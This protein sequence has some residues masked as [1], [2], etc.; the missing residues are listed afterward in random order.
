MIK[1][2][3]KMKYAVDIYSKTSPID[4]DPW[5]KIDHFSTLNQATIFCKIVVDN[6]L[7]DLSPLELN[8]HEILRR[9]VLYGDVPS[10][11]GNSDLGLFDA[12]EYAHNRVFNLLVD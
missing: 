11:N 7:N 5:T 2:E 12:Y 8:P 1:E 6:F 9:Y 4:V 10:I 3:V